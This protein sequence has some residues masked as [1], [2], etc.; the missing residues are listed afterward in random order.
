[1]KAFPKVISLTNRSKT[2]IQILILIV[3]LI[4]PDKIVAQTRSDGSQLRSAAAANSETELQKIEAT[5]AGTE[6]AGLARLLRGYLRL[7]ARD[8]STAIT[9]LSDSSI[10]RL[11]G[12]GDYAAYFRAQALQQAAVTTGR[13]EDAEREFRLLAQTYPTSLLAREA[14]LQAANLAMTRGDYQTAADTVALLAEKDDGAALKL[15]ADCLEKLGRPNEAV[16]TLRKLFFDA[17]QSPEAE[18]IGDR[19]AAL[20]GSTAAGDVS[21]L[22]RRADKLSD[23]RLYA[24]AGA[25]YEQIVRQ[26][27]NSATDEAWLRAGISYYKADSF[28]QSAD[29]LMKVRARTPKMAADALYHLGL[30]QLSL[31]ADTAAIQTL[32]D[33][34]KSSPSSDR[35]GDLLYAI[36][37]YYEKRERGD[38]ASAFYTQLIRQFP[39]SPNSDEAHFWM[40]WRAHEAKD[41][42]T[43]ARLLTE[44]LANYGTVTDNRGK[45][46]FWAAVNTERSG[47]KARAMTLYQAML[48]RYGAGWFGL[49]AER[50]IERLTREGVRPRSADSDLVLRRAVEGLQ[51]INLPRETIKD[52]DRER[53]RKAELLMQIAL[54]QQ[55]NAELE[56]ARQNAPNSPL[57]NLRIAQIFRT[58]GENV[59]AINALKRSYPDYGQTLPEEMS[60][61][62]WDVFY[63][64]KWWSNIKE[65]A[66]R[67]NLDPY[68]IA[69]LIRQETVF[70]H[71]ARSRAN[72]LGVM[73]LLP[74]TAKA[75]A[76]S[77]NAGA[78]SAND[79]FNPN[80]NIKLGVA[81]VKQLQNEF[82]SFEYVAAAYNGGETR[83]RRWLRE[84]PSMDIE[85]WVEAIPLSETRL[86]VQGVYRNTRIYQRLYDDQGRFRANVPER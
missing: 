13:T 61:E 29:A 24:L 2:L 39:Q 1:M 57:V 35:V 12:L 76:R 85:D 65:E 26:F 77:N 79:L 71:M 37:R 33:L 36:G 17:P 63:P 38:Q 31:K 20:G 82:R 84:W 8:F 5:M 67:H 46:A 23:A 64:L 75:V 70:N 78:I 73:Q 11:T 56:A 25:A 9:L 16:L 62:V 15:R 4:A 34:R 86:Y 58:Q 14:I 69:G 43:A 54:H 40:A 52:S 28:K 74:S 68:Q 47:D 49:N 50:R 45:A 55:A 44:H 6:S 48:K 21:M 81:Y 3:A 59:A 19:L 10:A 42:T 32:S 27:P 7:Q 80:L 83:V 41:Q 60:R 66:R 30:A 22:R 53:V 18:K 72:A 51:T